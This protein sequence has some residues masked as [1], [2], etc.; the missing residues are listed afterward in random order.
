MSTI[1]QL[2]SELFNTKA[3]VKFV[4]IP[5][6][7]GGEIVAGLLSGQVTM[8]FADTGPVL[9]QIKSGKLRALATSGAKRF[10]ELPDLPT[11]KEAG[12]AGVEVEG[13]S[14]LVDP[15]GTPKAIVKKL[16]AE[17]NAILNDPATR[18]KL[19]EAGANVAAL[20]IAEFATFVKAEREKYERIIRVTGVKPE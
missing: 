14:G 16:E 6:K 5:F 20:S 1:F 3:G 17:I 7:S 8:A 9:P 2:M 13:F 4:H 18:Q 11:M 10:P 15:A 19:V 12:I